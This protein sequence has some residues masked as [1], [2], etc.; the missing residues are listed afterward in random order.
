MFG[1]NAQEHD[2]ADDGEYPAIRG[3]RT[4]ARNRLSVYTGGG[5][6][7][8]WKVPFSGG[9]LRLALSAMYDSLFGAEAA[10]GQLELA[11][12]TQAEM[13]VLNMRH[14]GCPG[15]TNILSFP[16]PAWAEGPGELAMCPDM[17]S[18][19]SLLYRQPLPAYTLRMLAHGMAHLA[20]YDHG[21]EM[22]EACALA[23]AAAVE[24]LGL[25][26]TPNI[27]SDPDAPAD[28]GGTASGPDAQGRAEGGV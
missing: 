12:V 15:P 27:S 5:P 7:T 8:V 16:S 10:G 13:S 14:M 25:P 11:L 22:D 17:L 9:E 18:L 28:S 4:A 3:S 2:A 23:E 1:E 21:P 19:E 26:S 24:L 6:E 20:G